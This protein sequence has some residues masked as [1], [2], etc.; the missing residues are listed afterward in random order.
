MPALTDGISDSARRR[1]APRDT[2]ADRAQPPHK[3]ANR[4]GGSLYGFPF[5]YTIHE[6]NVTPMK[7]LLSLALALC[8]SMA[9]GVP[10][11]AANITAAGSTGSTPVTLT[12]DAATFSVTVPTSIAIKVNADASVTCPSAS[13]VRITNNSSGAV[14]VSKI[15]MTNGAWSLVSYDGGNRAASLANQPIDSKL[16]GFQL[17]ANSDNAA[18]ATDGAQTL[19]HDASKWVISPSASLEIATAA[20]ATAVSES[21]TAGDN[22]TAANVVFTIGWN[23]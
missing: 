11:F 10:A 6:R 2:F 17:T 20:I 5:A 18:T 1:E 4:K 22:V 21:I 7:K 16:L 13:A 19:T 3:P 8:L 15:E 23:D 12:A 14:K 9:L